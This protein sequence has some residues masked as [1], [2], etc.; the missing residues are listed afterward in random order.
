[1]KVVG[2]DT[3]VVFYSNITLKGG[4][5]RFGFIQNKVA[6]NPFSPAMIN[7]VILFKC[8]IKGMIFQKKGFNQSHSK[9][10]KIDLP[11]LSRLLCYLIIIVYCK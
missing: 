6:P 8:R 5:K 7:G 11:T 2:K 1:M 4:V 9:L 10:S 3:L